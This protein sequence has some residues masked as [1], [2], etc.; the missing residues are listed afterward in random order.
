MKPRILIFPAIALIAVSTA[1]AQTWSSTAGGNWSDGLNWDTT[2]TAPLNDGTADIVF[3]TNVASPN[4]TS[5]VD[6]AY[7]V[8]S[9]AFGNATGAWTIGGAGQLSIGAGGI[10]LNA[11]ASQTINTNLT[12][13]ASQ[14][15][16][17]GTYFG[18]NRQVDVAG[19][20]TGASD[21]TITVS[22]GQSATL[23]RKFVVGGANSATLASNWIVDAGGR[24][25]VRSLATANLGTGTI[26]VNPG[27]QVG[28]EGGNSFIANNITVAGGALGGLGDGGGGTFTGNVDITTDSFVNTTRGSAGINLGGAGTGVVS[29]TGNLTVYADIPQT[30]YMRL[31]SDGT[32]IG[33]AANTCTGTLTI[34]TGGVELAKSPDGTVAWAGDV[35]INFGA[36]LRYNSFR[37][38][39]IADTRK[40]TINDGGKWDLTH[41]QQ[42]NERIAALEVNTLATDGVTGEPNAFINDTGGGTTANITLG[43]GGSL[44]TGQGIFVNPT[45]T[46]SGVGIVNKLSTV[47][48]GALSPGNADFPVGKLTFARPLSLAAGLAAGS[49]KF[50][51]GAPTTA[52]TDYDSVT[53]DDTLIAGSGA[54]LDIGAGLLEFSSFQFTNLAGFAAGTYTLIDTNAAITG[55]LGGS[56]TGTI[57]GLNATLSLGD[58]GKDVILTVGAGG[59]PNYTTWAAAFTSPVLSDTASTADPDNDGLTNAVEYA[60]GL[61][62]RFSSPSPGVYSGSTLTFTKGA[63]AKVNGDVTYQIETSTTLGVAPSPWTVDVAN[64]T[65]GPDTIAIVFPSGPAK[66]F[67]RLKVT[68]AP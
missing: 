41:G 42:H 47:Q 48:G 65:N 29:G 68:L 14:T 13:G 16:N 43:T 25:S 49:L 56:L 34:N 27:G 21:K 4:N 7:S 63:E 3:N 18:V 30:K 50:G 58:S 23:Y 35:V 52:G 60:L 10:A 26:T 57:N 62:P 40:V 54:I 15:W 66:N 24:L 67:A 2:P 32:S 22:G 28:G 36:T 38:N 19:T 53:V 1:S 55:T 20:L 45:G 12:I 11:N 31:G 17:P 8:N 64:V 5:T 33:T 37:E 61:D 44:T 9:L 59:G 51:L 39:L 46:L 6:T